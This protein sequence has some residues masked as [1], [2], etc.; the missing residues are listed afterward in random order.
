MRHLLTFNLF[1]CLLLFMSS[2]CLYPIYAQTSLG[3][4]LS[5]TGPSPGADGSSKAP[6][7]SYKNVID[8]NTSTY[9]GARSSSN[10][11]IAVKWSVPVTAN[12]IIIRELGNNITSWRLETSNGAS[13]ATGT[14]AGAELIIQFPSTTDDKFRFVILT[15]NASPEISEFEV[16]NATSSTTTYQLSTTVSGSGTVDPS[17]GTYDEGSSVTLTATPASGWEFS[18]WSGSASGSTNPL[19]IIMD[20]N[21]SITATFVESS[22]SPTTYQLT[23]SV[24]GEGTVDPASGT[25]D[26]GSSVTLTASPASGW[27]FSG[28]SG[29]A[30]GSTNPLTI[31][32]DSDKN[33]TATFTQTTT[34]P[35]GE[36]DNSLVG[37]ATLAG[38]TTGGAGGTSVT[39][40]TGTDL[41]NAIRNKGTQPLIIYVEGVITPANSSGLTKIDVKD[42]T[43]ISILGAGAGAE[44]NGIG[45]KVMRASNVI[46]R[47]LKIHHVDIGDKDC[48][49]IEGPADHIWVDHCELYNSYQGVNKDYYDGLL[50]AKG[51]SEYITF[52]WNYL[53]DSWKASLAGSSDTDNFDR[54]I[55]YH[56]NYYENINSRLPLF[57]FGNGHVFN[58]YYKGV[59]SSAINSRMGACVKIENNYFENVQNPYVTAYSSEDGYGDISGNEL[60]NCTFN[61]STDVRELQACTANIPYSYSQVL[62]TAA[63]VPSVVM[64]NAGVGKIDVTASTTANASTSKNNA[65]EVV[66]ADQTFRFYPN[67]FEG[68]STFEVTLAEDGK[69]RISLFNLQGNR[70]ALI[71]DEMMKAGKNE[72]RYENSSIQPGVYFF[73][74]ET[75][76]GSFRRKVLVK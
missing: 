2:T 18:G 11:N 66:E 17:S 51:Q 16:Y 35:P 61:Y 41:Q 32:M 65:L 15:S 37:Y 45:I 56:H 54:K 63:E 59:E 62:H 58:N 19:A 53:H 24:S 72:I 47:N 73:L 74:L 40:S 26:A 27:E 44:F 14:S 30:S 22:T 71:A 76:E 64:A 1:V 29:S 21:K 46:I 31:S 20:S 42:V 69:V 43:D 3:D 5:I 70:I 33:I 10:E 60:V 55:T 23:T 8:G 39:V 6:G 49:G 36:M 34:N 28:W 75:E 9:W 13:L 12:T 68:T 7:T 52:S 48:I 67:P 25:Y 38:G 50:D 4:N 57:R